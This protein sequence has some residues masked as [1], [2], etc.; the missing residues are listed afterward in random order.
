MNINKLKNKFFNQMKF[1]EKLSSFTWFGVG[2]VAE[3]LF[4]PDNIDR[5]I[6]FIKDKPKNLSVFTIGAGSNILI[7]D[8]GIK[9]IS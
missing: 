7:R 8:N 9:G 3:I 5:V 1:N 4:V 2:G 6:N